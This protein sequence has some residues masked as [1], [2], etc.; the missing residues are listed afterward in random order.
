MSFKL[1]L[2]T[3]RTFVISLILLV[4]G[5]GV[6]YYYG[7]GAINAQMAQPIRKVVVNE[8]VPQEY[9][10]VDFSLFW[11]VWSKLERDYFEPERIDPEEMVYGAIEGMVSSLD[12]P[13]TVFL[14]PQQQQR[15]E[16]DLSGAFEGVGI[17]LGYIDSQLAVMSPLR[18]MPAEREGV[19]AGDLILNIKD[20]S[21]D[22]DIETVGMSLPEAVSYIRGQHG[23]P[24]TL[25]LY[26]ES[27]MQP[28]EVTIVRDT[29][30]IPS[31][32]LSFVPDRDGQG[33]IAHI[34]LSRFG[35]RTEEEWNQAIDEILAN[36]QVD[37]V[38]LDVRNNPGGYLEGAIFVASE[39][40]SDG[41]VVKQQGRVQSQEF[42]V[43]RRGELT[44]IPVVVLMNRGSA[45]ASEIVAGAL[46]DRKDAA[47]VGTKTFGKGTVQNAEDLREGT[48]IHITT[49][50][51]LLPGGDW[52]HETGIEP[53]IEA[54]N[55]AE[56]PDVDEMLEAA[57]DAFGATQE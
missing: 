10:E 4:L 20:E 16:E 12:D 45:S 9:Q 25:T 14:P 37:G 35:G 22:L 50:R 13:Y 1:R 39:F 36:S 5:G 52:I 54:T 26:R 57:L 21:K 48:G 49:S 47:L 51:W 23:V 18:G 44:D 31:V 56:T 24:V 42:R 6:G 2:K 15:V 3:I 17:Q 46:R 7:T 55:S 11:E 8:E 27:Q 30:V 33:E 40:I 38:I 53:D 19:E 34:Q 29:I 28:F 32:E 43:N 41:P